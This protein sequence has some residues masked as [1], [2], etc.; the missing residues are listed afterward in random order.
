MLR[1]TLLASAAAAM[2]ALPALARD[3]H[4]IL[5]GASTYTNLD[6]RFWLRGPANDIDLVQ[7]F[8]TTSASTPFAPEN[9][10]ILAD[11]IEG[12]TAPTL[13]A[14]RQAFADLTETVQPGDFVYL[15]FSGHGSQAPAADPD[16]E[17]DGL[18]ELFLPVDIGP[19][20]DTVGTVENALVDDE[21]GQMIDALRARGAT[22]WAVFDSCHSGT[23]T[24]AA[25]TGDDDVRLRKLDPRALGIPDAALADAE[26]SSRAL[27]DPRARPESPVADAAPAG[28]TGG[29]VAFFAAQ[30]NETTPEKRLP[31]GKKGRRSQG[32]FTFV[33]FETLA[34]NP[35]IT[36]RQ[37]GQE[38]LRRYAVKN[39][40]RSTPMFE[41]DLDTVVFSGEPVKP[42]T[43]WP[44]EIG[45]DVL[46]IPAGAL[47]NLTEG[48]ELALFAS[49]ADADE[50]VL[51]Y[52]R[53]DWADAFSAEVVPIAAHGHE[54]LTPDVIPNGA[55]LRKQAQGMDFTLT[56]ALPEPDAANHGAA[57][58]E[59]L[60]VIRTDGEMSSRISFVPPG[61]DA[62]I[63]MAFLPDSPRP[64]AVWLLPSSGLFDPENP[65]QTPSISIADKSTEDL[66]IVLED[67]LGHMSRALNL[68][69][70]GAGYGA[71]DLDVDVE[72]RTKNKRNKTL[73]TLDTV[74][75]PKLIPGDEVHILARNNTD[76]PVDV[77]VLYVG[78]DYSISHF[79][80]G[81]M[82][83]GDS[84]K[85]GLLRITDTAFGR[86]RVIMVLTPAKPQSVVENLAFMEQAE[87]E[88]TRG[89]ASSMAAA[90]MQAGFGTTTR[91][92]IA[93]DDEEDG[94][95]G[96][97][98]QFEIDAVPGDG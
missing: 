29:F 79:F 45:G 27:P 93:L 4:A 43:Q 91:G 7:R 21:I 12:S 61:E 78:S 57:L 3:N 51:G 17:L 42:V 2:L 65:G 22:V 8:L 54:A 75:V 44:V 5:I 71:S 11:G 68:L 84:L 64:G 16:S 53:V 69:K 83:P 10:T 80:S 46:T 81:R 88:T 30:T 55:Y 62:D 63:R 35:G 41:G 87:L 97:V 73:R 50:A 28:D 98:L 25:P 40:A 89:N 23:A 31:K 20:N 96:A 14:I 47:H 52:F 6:E 56:V 59:A 18:D 15:H 82:Q 90:F 72:L 32:V 60:A 34:Q 95:G 1:T 19:W 58:A 24:R 85:K 74:A 77:N 70:I 66:A 67:T 26:T 86:D 9:V 37:L 13:A 38:V 94:P 36:Y 48:A 76:Q 92:A 33:L 39:M 49:A